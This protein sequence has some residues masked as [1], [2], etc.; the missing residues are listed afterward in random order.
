MR[1]VIDANVIVS[2]LLSPGGP[3]AQL[4]EQFERG[5]ITLVT[6]GEQIEELRDVLARPR[7]TS[8][9]PENVAQRFVEHLDAKATLCGPL[10]AI[11][12]FPI[13]RMIFFSLR[14]WRRVSTDRHRRYATP[15]FPRIVWGNSDCHG[16]QSLVAFW[17]NV[18]A[19]GVL[20]AL[21]VIR[22]ARMMPVLFQK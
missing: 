5:L 7:I 1:V 2:G 11:E 20:L 8:R 10:P 12:A 14:L 17:R 13:R 18:V 15:A 4:L 21:C 6:S 16:R 22:M 3:P 9:F 19:V